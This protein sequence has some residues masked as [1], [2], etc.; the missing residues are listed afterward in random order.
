[1]QW[2]TREDWKAGLTVTFNPQILKM[3]PLIPAALFFMIMGSCVL[4]QDH[5]P[6]CSRY[7]VV[8]EDN[9]LAV[10]DLRSDSIDIL[11]TVLTLDFTN[12]ANS[13]I[14]GSAAI[15][16]KALQ[17]GTSSVRFDFEGLTV[18]S[19]TGGMV[20]G[21]SQSD[22][23]LTVQFNGVLTTGQVHNVKVYYH[24]SPQKDA[25]G[26]GGFYF[27]GGF[28]WNLGVGFADDPHSYGRIWFPCFDNFIERSTFEFFIRTN[29]D[30]RAACNGLLAGEANNGDGTVTYHWQMDQHIP[31]YLAC[32]AVGSYEIVQSVF[33]G[34]EATFPVQVHTRASDSTNLKSSFIH[35][36]DAIAAFEAAYG[37]YRFDKVGYSLV[38]FNSGAMEHATNIAYPISAA[39]GTLGSES[40]MAHELAHMWWGDNATCQTDGD[41]WINEGWASFSEYLFQEAV[42]GRLAYEDAMKEDLRYMLQFGHHAEETYRPVSGQP[43]EYVYGD[44]VYKKGAIAAHNLRGYLGDEDFFNA[45][46]A[47]MEQYQYTPVSSD[48]LEKFFSQH[49]GQDL[50]WFFRDWIYTPGY[51]V[52]VLDSFHYTASG[53]GFDVELFLQQKLKGTE[54]FHEQVPVYYTVYDAN[55]NKEEGKTIMS[56]QFSSVVVATA[57]EPHYVVLYEHNELAGARTTDLEVVKEPGGMDLIN[58]FWD[59]TVESLTDSALVNFEHIWSYPDPI[60]A[61]TSKAWRMSNYHYWKVSGIGLDNLQMSG[62][63]FYDGRL[64]GNT[65]YLDIDLVSA[66]EDSLLLLYRPD[67][68]ADWEEYTH[69]SRNVLGSSVN[70]FGLIEMS[71][72][73]PGEYVLAN[74][75][76][77]VLRV[78]LHPGSGWA[79]VYPNPA[80]QSITVE[81]DTPPKG[82]V[83]FELFDMSGKR[84]WHEWLKHTTSQI[85]V[86]SLKASGYYVYK[87]EAGGKNL[88]GRVLIETSH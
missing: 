22:T 27:S 66:T 69:Y 73:L 30:K 83:S 52:V 29:A 39:N 33:A 54:V 62:Q 46:A 15:D 68:A 84:V 56:G 23:Q 78:D 71:V 9:R 25:S 5:Q 21:F 72:I 17:P 65:G 37:P 76:H 14:S 87:I 58:M 36:P 74:V 47:F 34:Q 86:H 50:S 18:D 48:T 77:R 3:K 28:A 42:Y 45:A 59:V 64:G 70:A 12:M 10:E 4:A 11:H 6:F 81:L 75:D 80:G 24:G 63:F 8:T 44:H 19:V 41:M 60:K 2:K 31:S 53:S 32:V 26:W 79:K 88:T 38:P 55:W 13:V 40:L 16:L 1:M 57:L 61:F 85:D 82:E 43:H 7:K 67:C 49:S 20:N 51:S 35:L